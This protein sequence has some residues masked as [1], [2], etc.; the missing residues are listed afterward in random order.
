MSNVGFLSSGYGAASKVLS[1]YIVQCDVPASHLGIPRIA[2]KTELEI[3][4]ET[5]DEDQPDVDPEPEINVELE[6]LFIYKQFVLKLQSAS[7]SL[8]T[9]ES[10]GT[11]FAD[12]AFF[13]KATYIRSQRNNL[14]IAYDCLYSYCQI[15][16]SLRAFVKINRVH[17]FK[18]F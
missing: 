11:Y 15:Y 3:Q 1:K 18:T 14:W 7:K 6:G 12:R 13:V 9:S 17:L 2:R 8:F 4:S 16:N 5:G 10:C